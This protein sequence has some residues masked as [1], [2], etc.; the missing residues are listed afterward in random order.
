MSGEERKGGGWD[1]AVDS[2]LHSTTTLTEGHMI[3]VISL[4]VNTNKRTH[5]HTHC[6]LAGIKEQPAGQ[7]GPLRNVAPLRQSGEKSRVRVCVC[8]VVV[9]VTAVSSLFRLNQASNVI[10]ET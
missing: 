4:L 2:T 6:T 5:T 3:G 8:V 10:L 1:V 9:V 7:R